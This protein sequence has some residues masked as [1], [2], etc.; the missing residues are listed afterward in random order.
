MRGLKYYFILLN[1]LLFSCSNNDNDVIVVDEPTYDATIK[2][3]VDNNC[4]SCHS[5]S[6]N[7]E[8][9]TYAAIVLKIEDG[10]FENAVLV[11]KSM[12]K[13]GSLTEAE[14]ANIEKWIDNNYPEY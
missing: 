4:M 11:E 13:N 6:Y 3:I 1:L 5:S 9:D 7:P 8:I 10:T 14:L 12:P 2:S